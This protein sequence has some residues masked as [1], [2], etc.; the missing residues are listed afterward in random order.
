MRY[1]LKCLIYQIIPCLRRLIYSYGIQN[2]SICKTLTVMVARQLTQSI[3]QRHSSSTNQN[4]TIPLIP[5]SCIWSRHETFN[6]PKVRKDKKIHNLTKTEF[7]D[8]LFRISH[9]IENSIPSSAY[10]LLYNLKQKLRNRRS[11]TFMV[12]L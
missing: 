12:Y 11:S 9:L 3:K 4:K 7:D 6:L 2:R 1:K 5:L 8:I 10:I